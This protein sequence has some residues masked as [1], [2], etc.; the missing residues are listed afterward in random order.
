MLSVLL[1]GIY[2][3]AQGD[4]G[5][6][7]DVPDGRGVS[8]GVIPLGL[9]G[10]NIFLGKHTGLALCQVIRFCPDL[11]FANVLGDGCLAIL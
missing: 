1:V 10:G 7:I 5:F 3:F 4:L 2:A 11:T 6:T 8:G 9:S